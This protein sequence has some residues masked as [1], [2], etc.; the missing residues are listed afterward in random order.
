MKTPIKTIVL[1]VSMACL[2]GMAMADTEIVVDTDLTNTLATIAKQGLDGSALNLA[3]NTGDVNAS[4]NTAGEGFDLSKSHY[5]FQVDAQS[6]NQLQGDIK[7]MAL[8]ASNNGTINLQQGS[9]TASNAVT[10]DGSFKAGVAGYVNH[11]D[12]ETTA[13]SDQTATG[14]QASGGQS[15][16]SAEEYDHGWFGSGASNESTSSGGSISGWY[17]N[18]NN[19]Y[20]T[21]S[22]AFT[23][24]LAAGVE[25][26]IS[27]SSAS[28]VASTASNYAA[29]NV[30][31]NSGD[32]NASVNTTGFTNTLGNIETT[33]VGAV[34][35]GAITVTVK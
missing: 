24:A 21:A 27:T 15:S 9:S 29:A 16:S 8:G 5:G 10:L 20:N 19:Y 13:S 7:T 28:S 4:V 35:T 25:A 6:M 23:A 18:A 1:S 31:F 26:E 30:A 12:S 11:A 22:E 33:A 2:S 3:I 14:G 34:N 17:Y 32:I